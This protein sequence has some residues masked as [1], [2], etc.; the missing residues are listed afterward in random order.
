M[1]MRGLP[2]R[3]RLV[4]DDGLGLVVRPATAGDGAAISWVLNDP[5]LVHVPS[6][7]TAHNVEAW[8]TDQDERWDGDQDGRSLLLSL[9]M[10]GAVVGFMSARFETEYLHF[11]P[12]AAMVPTIQWS[13]Y[14]HSSAA[15]RGVVRRATPLVEPTLVT[16]F[17]VRQV[18]ALTRDTNTEARAALVGFEGPVDAGDGELAFW[19]GPLT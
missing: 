5:S 17:G 10:D 4:H 1:F 8:I 9:E 6:R 7:P 15:K 19:R 18:I 16:H 12:H 14:R 2:P 11:D 13:A 3:E